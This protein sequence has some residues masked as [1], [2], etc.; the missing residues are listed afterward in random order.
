[1]KG[2]NLQNIGEKWSC[3]KSKTEAKINLYAESWHLYQ[4]PFLQKN[5]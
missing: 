4:N 5:Q 3:F 2:P 1:M